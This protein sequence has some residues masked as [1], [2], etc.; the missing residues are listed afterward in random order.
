MTN[1]GELQERAVTW[2]LNAELQ[3]RADFARKMGRDTMR[4]MLRYALQ[5]LA[6]EAN[7]AGVLL[8]D[9]AAECAEMEAVKK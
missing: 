4:P 7:A 3:H 6:V 2:R 1:F 9:V 5:V 8:S